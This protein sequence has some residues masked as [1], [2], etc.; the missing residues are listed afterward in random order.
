ML[1]SLPTGRFHI[2]T[3]GSDVHSTQDTVLEHSGCIEDAQ[4]Q[5]H[6]FH[7]FPCAVAL[8]FK[9]RASAAASYF[10]T[11][12]VLWKN[13]FVHFLLD[14]V[15]QNASRTPFT[16]GYCRVSIILKFSNRCTEMQLS[17]YSILRAEICGCCCANSTKWHCG[18]LGLYRGEA[19]RPP[20][21]RAFIG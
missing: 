19:A 14:A 20:A 16:E 5:C 7:S 2:D 15:E 9:L 12:R 10:A 21:L 11:V 1:Q 13:V 8:F 6:C 3:L 18:V 4:P 17:T